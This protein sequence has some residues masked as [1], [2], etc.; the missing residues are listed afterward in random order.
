MVWPIMSRRWPDHLADKIN[1]V[2][3]DCLNVT[4]IIHND[5]KK[6]ADMH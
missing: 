2:N 5:F 3:D 6:Y 1:R 4:E